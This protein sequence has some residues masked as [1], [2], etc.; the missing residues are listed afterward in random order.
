M[1]ASGHMKENEWWIFEKKILG[2]SVYDD[3]NIPIISPPDFY[4][5]ECDENSRDVETA[6]NIN[7]K[8]RY[9]V[10]TGG[11]GTNVVFNNQPPS[12]AGG[13][14]AGGSSTVVIPSGVKS[15]T[16]TSSGFGGYGRETM[17]ESKPKTDIAEPKEKKKQTFKDFFDMLIYGKAKQL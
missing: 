13:G 15:V 6:K 10:G 16:I 8:T 5:A 7:A 2:Y 4:S 12:G 3:D 9:G 14:G 1:V 11:V 17:E